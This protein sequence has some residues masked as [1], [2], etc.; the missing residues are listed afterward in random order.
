MITTNRISV[1]GLINQ[2]HEV[3]RLENLFYKKVDSAY[4]LKSYGLEWDFFLSDRAELPI[5]GFLSYLT[6]EATKHGIVI[7]DLKYS[8]ED[9]TFNLLAK[10]LTEETV[11]LT[12]STI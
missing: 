1:T 3:Q 5:N 7:T 8:S 6:Q 12:G 9:F 10:L 2:Q 4:Y 11:Y